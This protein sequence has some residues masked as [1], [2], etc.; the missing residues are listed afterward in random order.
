MSKCYV[1]KVLKV[2]EGELGYK[3][4]KSNASMDD[5][6]A[7]AGSGNYTKYAR[8]FD[9][10]YPNWYNG[11]KNGFAW[12]DMFVDWCFLTAYGYEDALRLLCQP[13]KS[14]GAGCTYSR[15]YYANKGQFYTSPKVGDQIFFGTSI[16][17]CSHTGLVVDVDS[18]K[19]YTI[20]GN[21]SDMVAKRSY[22]LNNS[23]I[24]GYGRPKYDAED[25]GTSTDNDTPS[26]TATKTVDE[27]AKEV[28]DGVW[29]NGEDRKNALTAAGYDY[30][31]VQSRVNE[32]VKTQTTVSQPAI[33][34]NAEKTIWDYLMGKINNAYG[35]AGLM[36]NLYAE[37]ALKP[38]NLQ[39]NGNTKLGMTDES[40]CAAVNSG[41][42]SE[43]TFVHDSY[44][45]GL[46]QWTY[47]S[48]K[49]ALI[50]FAKSEMKPIEDLTMQLDFLWKELTGGYTS[51]LEVLTTA[52]SIR[53]ASDAV[54]TKY[55]RPADQG[56]AVQV[57]RAGY[58]QIYYDKYATASSSTPSAPTTSPAEGKTEE[59]VDYAQSKETP[60]SNRYRTTAALNLRVG[61][62]THKKIIKVLPK[63][64]VV[65]Y[66][67]YYSMNG[68]VKWM[69]I[70]V[71]GITGFVSSVYLAKA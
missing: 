48:R 56:E 38:E 62:G 37:S 64:T 67:G 49:Q 30:S 25:S 18:S 52:T 23:R 60:E 33:T 9:Q 31:A 70:A 54:L 1:S 6:T 28:L 68:S 27:L 15:R 17:D 2:A 50:D 41:A 42:Y 32:L 63:G 13:E 51:T 57:R 44:G 40:F 61:A 8:D 34:I 69:Y 55:E 24:V 21:T 45:F 3:E 29:G 58:G 20:E 5:K 11:K 39:N 22:A 36:G 46:A 59:K 10:K 12:C 26:V 4:K 16:N 71:D 66:Y 35:V 7:N 43:N 65:H 47:Y 14:A 19:V 53:Q